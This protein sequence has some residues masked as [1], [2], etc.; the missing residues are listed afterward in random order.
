[1]YLF[2]R[3]LCIVLIALALSFCSVSARAVA[4]SNWMD[5]QILVIEFNGKQQR[6][7]G[8]TSDANYYWEHGTFPPVQSSGNSQQIDSIIAAI[9]NHRS[10]LNAHAKI[11]NSQTDSIDKLIAENKRMRTESAR[12]Q[13]LAFTRVW[14]DIDGNS[15]TGIFIE[16]NLGA[17]KVQKVLDNTSYTIPAGRLTPACKEMAL[18]LNRFK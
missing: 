11:I 10:V 13:T 4:K 14:T 5:G 1:M 3:N 8:W 7:L 16:Y 12:L 17:V 2:M 6:F 18:A 9:N 15:F